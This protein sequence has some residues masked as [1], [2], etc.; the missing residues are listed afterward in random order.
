MLLEHA[1]DLLKPGYLSLES[2][3][4]RLDDGTL[5]V[6]ALTLM[7]GCKRYMVDWWFGYL[8]TSEHYK[9]W[10]SGD[11]VWTEWDENW[12]PGQYVGATSM[13]HEYIGG[14][15][16]KLRIRFRDPAEFLDTGRFDDADVSGVVCA[17]TGLL[18]AP[19]WAGHLIHFCRD[20]DDGCEMRSRFWLGDMDPPD[21]APNREA[22]MELFP[23]EMGKAL[24]QHCI[25]E[26]RN[27]ATFLPDLYARETGK[28]G[29]PK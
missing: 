20:T 17:R 16:Q 15:L 9:L 4:Q 29:P 25:E 12:K 3:Y 1:N 28:I 18:E 10:H 13:V 6:A 24:L 14:Q 8:E 5:L 21:I 26:M 23:D 22:R 7:P 27:L 11:H 2:G 19:V